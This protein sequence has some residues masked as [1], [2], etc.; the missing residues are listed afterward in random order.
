MAQLKFLDDTGVAKLIQMIVDK[1]VKKEYKTGSQTVF[2]VLSD[3]NLTD[4]LVQKINN[5]SDSSFSGNYSDLHGKPSINGHEL[6]SGANTLEDLGIAS[7]SDIADMATQSYVTSYVSGRGYQTATQV[8]S[9]VNSAVSNLKS[10]LL[11]QINNA[12][13]SVLTYKGTKASTSGLPSS[14]NKVGDIWFVQ[15]DNSEYAWDG[16]KWEE[17]GAIVDLSNYVQYTDL[18]PISTPYIE[19]MF[20]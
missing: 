12:V 7:A 3:N 16:T 1:F 14:G 11:T 19:S 17:L 4:E 9:T 10:D 18:V 15:A 13:A 6:A 5:A 2:K 8:K 20:D